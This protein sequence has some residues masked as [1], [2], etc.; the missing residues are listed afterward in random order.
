MHPLSIFPQLYSYPF[1][2]YFILRLTV[3]WVVLANGVTRFKKSYKFL[4]ILEFI[5]GIL[6]LIG[7]Y[8]QPALVAVILL[9]IIESWSD[10]AMLSQSHKMLMYVTIIIAFC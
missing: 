10:R 9:L 6:V 4:S 2:S 8:T 1:L 5:A 3:A 7:L